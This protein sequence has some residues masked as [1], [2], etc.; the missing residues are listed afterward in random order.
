MTWWQFAFVM[1]IAASLG[2]ATVPIALRRAMPTRDNVAVVR[3]LFDAGRR[4]DLAGFLG[5]VHPEVS[6]LPSTVTLLNEGD[7]AYYGREGVRRWFEEVARVWPVYREAPTEFRDLGNNRVLAMG[8]I[9]AENP[10]GTS[11]VTD[12]AWICIVEEGEVRGLCAFRNAED[13]VWASGADRRSGLDRRSGR[14]RR[15]PGL[16]GA[17]RR[18]VERRHGPPDRRSGPDRR[19]AIA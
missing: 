4:D 5:L 14:D 12:A 16:T 7:G 1:W 8:N 19:G 15:R 10:Q 3:S 2:L 11:L 6:W 13:A 18:M 9:A 17:R